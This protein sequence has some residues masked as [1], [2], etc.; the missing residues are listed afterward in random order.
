M[1]PPCPSL[2]RTKI[3]IVEVPESLIEFAL[4]DQL[5]RILGFSDVH[6]P[7]GL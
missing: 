4:L 1:L 5:E 2:L 6:F 7:W 3:L